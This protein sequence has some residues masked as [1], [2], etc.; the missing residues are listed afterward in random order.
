LRLVC[1]VG[2]VGVVVKGVLRRGG[3]RL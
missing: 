3:G 1:L 2:V